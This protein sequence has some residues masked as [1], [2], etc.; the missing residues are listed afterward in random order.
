MQ[1]VKV[2][3]R[4]EDSYP[5]KPVGLIWESERLPIMTILS[6]SRLPDELQ[7]RVKT[8]GDRIFELYYQEETDRW[9]CQEE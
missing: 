4:S 5:Q 7:F 8:T 6:R 1:E 9:L 2:I 3:C